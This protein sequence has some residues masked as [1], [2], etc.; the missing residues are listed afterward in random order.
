VNQRHGP[1]SVAAFREQFRY[2]VVGDARSLQAQHAADQLKVVL[3]P[4]MN[5]FEERF[6]LVKRF[7]KLEIHAFER[8]FGAL[9]PQDYARE[10]RK[11]FAYANFSIG[12]LAKSA[13]IHCEDTERASVR[14]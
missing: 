13:G 6:F 11:L 9:S 7:L 3:D 8:V 1:D 12:D 2:R 10:M 14:R 4:V 5:L